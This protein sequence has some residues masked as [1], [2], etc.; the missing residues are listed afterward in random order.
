MNRKNCKCKIYF[1][2][3]KEAGNIDKLLVC[4]CPIYNNKVYT[5]SGY[6]DRILNDVLEYKVNKLKRRLQILNSCKV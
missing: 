5:I 6:T 3:A 1:S 4:K 2:N